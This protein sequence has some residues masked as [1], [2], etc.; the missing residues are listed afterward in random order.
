MH[1]LLVL[2]PNRNTRQSRIARA[3]KSGRGRAR[4]CAT[5]GH[6]CERDKRSLTARGGGGDHNLRAHKQCHKRPHKNR[7]QSYARVCA[8]NALAR[9]CT[10][11]NQCAMLRTRDRPAGLHHRTSTTRACNAWSN[12]VRGS[13]KPKPTPTPMVT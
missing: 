6:M 4:A 3:S 1:S 5:K 12:C 13:P 11:H 8:P 7:P 9:D 10:N 2:R